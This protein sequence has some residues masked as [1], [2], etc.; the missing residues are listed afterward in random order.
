MTDGRCADFSDG[1]SGKFKSN[2]LA[3]RV[4]DFIAAIPRRTPWRA[5]REGAPVAFREKRQR[6]PDISCQ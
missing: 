4:R 3:H 5:K 6:L 2:R 1:G